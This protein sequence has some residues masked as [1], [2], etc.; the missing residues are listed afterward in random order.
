[1]RIPRGRLHL[2]D[3]LF[4]RE[5]RHVKCASAQVKNED[6]LLI[7]ALLVETICD[8]CRS[9]FVD[10]A[11]DVETRNRTRVLRRLALRV[12]EIGRNGHHRI[13]HVLPQVGLRNLL[14]LHQNH[15]GNLLGREILLLILIGHLNERFVARVGN[16]LERPV[17]H[18]RLNGRIRHFSTNQAL[19]VKDRIMRVHRCLVLRRIPN[20][21]LLLVECNI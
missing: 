7:V 5:Q 11:Q 20:K 21:T 3:A 17:F 16:D 10:D 15:R 6:V 12:V 14:H 1:M 8:C 13:L 2:E 9:R 18:I 4:N 19:C